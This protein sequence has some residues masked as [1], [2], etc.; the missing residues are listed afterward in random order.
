[1]L[2]SPLGM[3][4]APSVNLGKLGLTLE[5]AVQVCTFFCGPQSL[6]SP[7][8]HRTSHGALWQLL[9][10]VLDHLFTSL[11]LLLNRVGTE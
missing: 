10:H 1:M 7:G 2:V 11:S 9:A 5:D 3:S 8:F 4:S 6:I